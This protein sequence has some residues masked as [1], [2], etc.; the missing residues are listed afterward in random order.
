[1]SAVVDA[2]VSLAELHRQAALR[3]VPRF[4]VLSKLELL[5]VLAQPEAPPE[6]R[7]PVRLERDGPLATIVLDDPEARNALGRVALDALEAAL[8]ELEAD[9]DVR[10]VA[11]HGAGS[12]FCS[13]A[14][15]HEFDTPDGGAELTERGGALF[16]RLAALPVPVVALLNGPAVGAGAELALAADWR[17]V[18]PEGDLRFVHV[19]LGLV[20]AFGGTGR[21]RDVVGAGAAL[22]LLAARAAVDADG[23]VRLGLASEIV[24]A[25]ELRE[26]ARDLAEHLEDSDRAAVAAVKR[27]LAAPADG[28]RAAER[29]AFLDA[30]PNRR[31]DRVP[32]PAR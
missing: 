3:G 16:D 11:V 6:P 20:P 25:D 26:R 2:S 17:L 19:G 27:T 18:A 13:G 1:M 15:V 4:R 29:A 7:P 22:L 12:V 21:L 24:S 8:E 30:W 31:L 5:E 9:H 23:A 28:A 10:L 32:Q 14:R